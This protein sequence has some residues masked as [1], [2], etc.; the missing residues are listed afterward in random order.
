MNGA[1]NYL[2][3]VRHNAGRR[4]AISFMLYTLLA[5][6]FCGLAYLA[7]SRW[8]TGTVWRI[9]PPA[10]NVLTS[11]VLAQS[12][13]VFFLSLQ[14]LGAFTV[15]SRA[16][17]VLTAILRGAGIGCAAAFMGRGLLNLSSGAW[18]YV[19]FTA[20][21][22]LLLLSALSN[23]YADCFLTLTG[24]HERRM[25]ASLFQEFLKSFGV[26]SGVILLLHIAGVLLTA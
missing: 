14:F 16:I 17:S 2:E 4:T 23:V 5:S 13:A 7:F 12:A 9:T 22:L 18:L 19:N 1:E 6:V 11:A 3:Y 26:L 25:R 21:L 20:L 8:D 15:F 24:I 10:G